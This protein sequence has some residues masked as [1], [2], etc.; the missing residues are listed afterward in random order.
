V[1]HLLANIGAVKPVNPVVNAVT[2]LFEF[3]EDCANV[4][5]FIFW[6]SGACL[7]VTDTNQTFAN[8]CECSLVILLAM[9]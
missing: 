6:I 8:S 5:N 7:K 1:Y 2:T 4:I 9:E 3:A